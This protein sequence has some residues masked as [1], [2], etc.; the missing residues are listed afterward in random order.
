MREIKKRLAK[1]DWERILF[2]FQ[3]SLHV[4]I[5]WTFVSPLILNLVAGKEPSDAD[6]AKFF[7]AFWVAIALMHWLSADKWRRENSRLMKDS[8]H[9]IEQTHDALRQ[10]H[11]LVQIIERLDKS[12]LAKAGIFIRVKKD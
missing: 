5:M 10:N 2:F 1:W 4:F 7:T 11:I 8:L 9:L 6:A 3:I 12:V